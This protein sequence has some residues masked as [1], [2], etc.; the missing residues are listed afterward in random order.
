[1]VLHYL[2]GTKHF[3]LTYEKF[4]ELKIVGYSYVD[5]TGGDSENP[6]QVIFDTHRRSYIM[7]KL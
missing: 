7:E 3:M 2:Q 4:D 6:N 1:M 5:F